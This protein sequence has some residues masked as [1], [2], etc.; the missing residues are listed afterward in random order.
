MAATADPEAIL[1]RLHAILQTVPG[2]KKVYRNESEIDE[3]QLP[4]ILL[5]DGDEEVEDLTWPT[6]SSRPGS[7]PA[8]VTI[9]PEIYVMVKGTN[10]TIGGKLS[11]I[12]LDILRLVMN[13]AQLKALA[14]DG[15]VRYEGAQTGFSLGRSLLGEQGVNISIRYIP[16]LKPEAVSA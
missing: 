15:N 10:A 3:T 8:R 12:R 16:D 11:A 6:N 7:A 14:L 2:V 13:D 5:L 1:A 9:R 4:L